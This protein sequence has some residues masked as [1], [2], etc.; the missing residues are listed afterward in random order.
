MGNHFLMKAKHKVKS[1]S[2]L[3]LTVGAVVGLGTTVYFVARGQMRADDIL[4]ER[5]KMVDLEDKETKIVPG[6]KEVFDL[7]WQCYI[8]AAIST[9]VTLAC[10]IGSQVISRKQIIGLMGTVGALTASR[11]QLEEAIREK[12]G[13][14]ALKELKKRM[15]MKQSDPEEKTVFVRVIAE[16]TGN[17]DLLCYEGYSG[18]WF[19]SSR[20]AVEEAEKT[21]NHELKENHYSSF[22][23]LYDLFGIEESHFGNEYGYVDTEHESIVDER[24]VIFENTLVRAADS[25]KGEDVLYIDIYT[26]PI[27]YFYEY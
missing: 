7:T 26:Y 19:R 5:G 8:P 14:D 11:N 22:N 3:L 12:Y 15:T 17:G 24:G 1:N 18:R 9:G 2:S 20:E 23:D 25:G 13:D 10:I 4:A 6:K 16:E 21:Y 27:E